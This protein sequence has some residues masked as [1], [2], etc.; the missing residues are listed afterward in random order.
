[1]ASKLAC[2]EGLEGKLQSPFV[3]KQGLA[4]LL[5]HIVEGGVV[6]VLADFDRFGGLTGSVVD[7]VIGKFT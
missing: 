1:M 6:L 2:I 7:Y 5:R 3:L 4:L